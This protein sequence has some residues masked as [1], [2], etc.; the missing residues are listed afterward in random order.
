[1]WRTI[2]VLFHESASRSFGHYEQITPN[3]NTAFTTKL[4]KWLNIISRAIRKSNQKEIWDQKTR[5][6]IRTTLQTFAYRK[7]LPNDN[8]TQSDWSGKATLIE[9]D[10]A[11]RYKTLRHQEIRMNGFETRRKLDRWFMR[12]LDTYL[13]NTI[14]TPLRHK[15]G[16]DWPED[17]EGK[18]PIDPQTRLDYQK[19]IW[20]TKTETRKKD[21]TEIAQKEWLQQLMNSPTKFTPD[22]RE[23][24]TKAIKMEELAE[25]YKELKTKAAPGPQGSEIRNGRTRPSY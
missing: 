6:D 2:K 23:E 14:R 5:S 24:L 11:A 19:E 16:L 15:G 10:L 21:T 8:D 18:I 20:E 25:T 9:M 22:M 13:E 4:Y 1:L 3:Q 17:A 7:I 12:D